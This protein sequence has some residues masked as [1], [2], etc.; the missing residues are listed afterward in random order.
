MLVW[1][2]DIQYG[3]VNHVTVP[4][5]NPPSTGSKGGLLI[6]DSHFDPV[7]RDASIVDGTTLKNMPSRA[8]SSNAAFNTFGSYPFMRVLPAGAD[9]EH[10]ALHQRPRR[11]P[12]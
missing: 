9:V 6:V 3:N 10:G 12:P 8:Q 5:F 11:S 2:R 7:R 1:Y 4:V